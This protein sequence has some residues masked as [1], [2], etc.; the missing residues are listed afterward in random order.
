[1][2]NILTALTLVWRGRKAEAGPHV[3]VHLRQEVSTEVALM[4]NSTLSLMRSSLM[5]I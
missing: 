3:W 2:T 4:Y 1:M 5:Y